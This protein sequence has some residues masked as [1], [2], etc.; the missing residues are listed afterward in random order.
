[1]VI[2]GGASGIG[3]AFS[4]RFI[5]EGSKVVIVDW[6]TSEVISDIFVDENYF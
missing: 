3:F 2:T 5:A 6:D 1:V 4:Q